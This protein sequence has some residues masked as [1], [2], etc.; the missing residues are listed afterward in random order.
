[1]EC[2]DQ[3]REVTWESVHSEDVLA[4]VVDDQKWIL[5]SALPPPV[6]RRDDCHGHHARACCQGVFRF[7]NVP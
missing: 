6:A 7:N 4:P 2:G 5:R 1:M 3:M